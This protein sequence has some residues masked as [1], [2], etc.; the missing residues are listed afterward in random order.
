MET[1]VNV[2]DLEATCWEGDPPP[3]QTSEVIEIGVC[4]YDPATRQR[5]SKH[6]LLVKPA[7]SEVSAFCTRLTGWTARALA[8]GMPFAQACDIDSD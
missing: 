5:Q 1:A 4:V 3:G 6:Q 2:L 8:S 7:R